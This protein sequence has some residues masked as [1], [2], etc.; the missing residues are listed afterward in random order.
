M[1]F[2]SLLAIV[3]VLWAGSALG[4]ENAATLRVAVHAKPPYA[5][6]LDGASWDGIGIELW[7]SVARQTG[8]GIEFIEMPVAEILPAVREGRVDAAVGEF[9]ITAENARGI[10]FS[11]PYLHSSIGVAVKAGAWSFDWFEV[12]SGFLNWTL[13]QAVL[14]I[15]AGM[16]LVS[17]LI[18]ALERHHQR[19]HFQGGMRGFGSAVWFSAVTMT[20]VGYGDKTPSTFVG[21]LIAFLWMLAGVL[22]VA[23]F[24]GAVAS[25][26][27]TARVN[28]VIA[29][30]DDLR[31]LSVGVVD[32]SE[33]A[34]LLARRGIRFA[35][36]P[37]IETAFDALSAS[38]VQAVVS[39]RVSLAY[40]VAHHGP[41]AGPAATELTALSLQ[42]A[43]VAVP[44][45]PNLPQREAVN[46]AILETVESDAWQ[47][48]RQRWLGGIDFPPR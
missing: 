27:A 31:R 35:T 33:S 22:L 16:F 14:L 19:G 26:V 46:L 9:D 34:R 1:R 8:L 40:M 44:M 38:R 2:L 36:F 43:M 47:A 10:E 11:P 20:T 29:R 17:F 28:G 30:T 23:S 42:D 12:L 4:A 21:R 24:T 48:V 25:S 13:A 41:G 37:D 6:M 45:R 7:Q 3:F 39:D 15:F 18:W 32:G 5:V